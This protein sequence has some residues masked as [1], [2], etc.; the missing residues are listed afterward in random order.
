MRRKM[1]R[2]RKKR[3]KRK[4]EMKNKIQIGKEEVKYHFL[5]MI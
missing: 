3:K 4:T 5:Q 1:K 2:M